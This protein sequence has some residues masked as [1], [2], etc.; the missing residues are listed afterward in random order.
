MKASFHG[1]KKEINMS[2]ERH[3]FRVYAEHK[4]KK[5]GLF[6]EKF[7]VQY[8]TIK[9]VTYCF[10]SDIHNRYINSD[11]M[12]VNVVDEWGAWISTEWKVISSELKYRNLDQ[13]Y[14]F[15]QLSSHLCA[16]EF[17]QYCKDHNISSININT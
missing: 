10:E 7:S 2:E 4:C 5:K 1:I 16:D 14:T 13:F 9:Q 15:N 12:L 17:L 6:K 11:E 3:L 8:T